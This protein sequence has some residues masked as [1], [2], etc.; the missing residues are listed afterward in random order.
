MLHSQCVAMKAPV[1]APVTVGG[2]EVGLCI[3]D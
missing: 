2:D 3:L 1:A